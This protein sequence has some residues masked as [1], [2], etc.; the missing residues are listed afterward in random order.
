MLGHMVSHADF[1][2]EGC[3]GGAGPCRRAAPDASTRGWPGVLGLAVCLVVLGTPCSL[4]LPGYVAR[5]CLHR[6]LSWHCVHK[7]HVCDSPVPSRPQL[8]FWAIRP[9]GPLQQ[10]PCPCCRVLMAMP[11]GKR[12]LLASHQRAECRLL[13]SPA[14]GLL[15]QALL[16]GLLPQGQ[17][18]RQHCHIWALAVCT[19]ASVK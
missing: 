2:C 15:Q 16:W 5:C 4:C 10:S 6:S 13:E 11:V 1:A 14:W 3:H 8:L 18:V 9:L 12:A 17:Q 7:T 19:I